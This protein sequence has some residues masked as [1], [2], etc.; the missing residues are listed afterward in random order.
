ML[1]DIALVKILNVCVLWP[2]VHQTVDAIQQWKAP[3]ALLHWE[4]C[5]STAS[6]GLTAKKPA[7]K[8]PTLKVL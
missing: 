4:S 8:L 2:S 6:D 3:I 1:A 7:Q 5:T